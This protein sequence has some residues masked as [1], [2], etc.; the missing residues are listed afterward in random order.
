VT[1]NVL[2]SPKGTIFFLS[3]NGLYLPFSFFI[4]PVFCR[5][6]ALIKV[7]SAMPFPMLLEVVAFLFAD[8]KL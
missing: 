1:S 8:N 7:L 2:P 3:Y 6:Q 5:H 4:C